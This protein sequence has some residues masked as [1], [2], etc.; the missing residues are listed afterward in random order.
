MPIELLKTL[1]ILIL[2]FAFLWKGGD[3][4][5]SGVSSLGKKLNIPSIILGLTLVSFGTSG[6]ELI[7]NIIASVSHKPDIIM[8]NIIGSNIANSLLILGLA[9]IL[10]PIQYKKESLSFEVIVNIVISVILY[11]LVIVFP[12]KPFIL[13]SIE[14]YV[15]LGLFSFYIYRILIKKRDPNIDIGEPHHISLSKSIFLFSSGCILLPLGGQWVVSSSITIGQLLHVSEAFMA[16]FAVA[17]GTSLPELSATVIAAKR[18]ENELALGNIIGSNVFNILLIL[19]LSST[20]S[21]I[22]V[23]P[24]LRLDLIVMI[25][26]SIILG[27]F[28]FVNKQQ[29][30]SKKQCLLFLTMYI[31]YFIYIFNRG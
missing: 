3:Y 11:A 25:L 28:F 5:I 14:G 1:S 19:G 23:L 4:L 30:Y 29:S 31:A 13:T 12:T 27:V 22:T 15:L 8:G 24:N 2:G 9:G 17:I 20:I 16:L 7:V 21:E 10:F 6:P 26:A 18:H